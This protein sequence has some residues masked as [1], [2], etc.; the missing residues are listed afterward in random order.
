[1]AIEVMKC[2]ETD[3]V[4]EYIIDTSYAYRGSVV[5][6]SGWDTTYN[7]AKVGLVASSANSKVALG[8]V[9]QLPM[10]N[11]GSDTADAVDKLAKNSKVVVLKKGVFKVWGGCVVPTTFSAIYSTSG[12]GATGGASSYSG[13]YWGR[14][15]PS[16]RATH[17]A[18]SWVAT[19]AAAE[20]GFVVGTSA[21]GNRA[22]IV[23]L[24][25]FHT[26]TGRP[27][28]LTLDVD[29]NRS[30]LTLVAG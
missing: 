29:F 26:T 15:Y 11:T 1:M 24:T 12:L 8:L 5:Y 4:G 30:G 27:V 18:G 2:E 3:F 14:A 21:W 20:T 10:V 16:I 23:D 28:Y 17:R 9:H 13:A 19:S 25:M 6:V 7:R 22:R